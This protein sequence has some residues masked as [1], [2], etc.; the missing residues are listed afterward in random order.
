M[1]FDHEPVVYSRWSSSSGLRPLSAPAT[2]QDSEDSE[3]SALSA[4][5]M[6]ALNPAARPREA[7]APGDSPCGDDALS[8]EDDVPALISKDDM[9]ALIPAEW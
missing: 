1:L 2:Q 5:E 8:S 6:P 9:P 3:D 4:D 7:A